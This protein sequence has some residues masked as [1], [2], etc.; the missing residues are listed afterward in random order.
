MAGML[1]LNCP[2]FD[3]SPLSPVHRN[4]KGFACP[5]TNVIG[6]SANEVLDAEMAPQPDQRRAF[7][8]PLQTVPYSNTYETQAL[9]RDEDGWAP[10]P[11]SASI[12]GPSWEAL[13]EDCQH[14]QKDFQGK[15]G[16]RRRNRAEQRYYDDLVNHV[17]ELHEADLLTK[18]TGDFAAAAQTGPAG[19]GFIYLS[20]ACNLVIFGVKAFAAV[21]SG[22][23]VLLAS[24]LDSFLDLASGSALSCMAALMRKQEKYKFPVGKTRMEPVGVVVFATLM[25]SC[26]LQVLMESAKRLLSPEQVELTT[27]VWLP[28]V[29]VVFV[30][31]ALFWYGRRVQNVLESRGQ[32]SSALEAQTDDHKNDVLT[33][34]LSLVGAFIASTTFAQLVGFSGGEL[35]VFDPLAAI[36]F[37]LYVIKNWGATALEQMTSLV[38][39]AGPAD[40]HR[41]ITYLAATHCQEIIAVDTV[42]AFTFGPRYIAEVD[43][44]LPPSMTMRVA[45]DIGESLQIR[46]ESLSEIERCYVHL[47]WETDHKPEHKS[48]V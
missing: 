29:L 6:A 27:G 38:G 31:G 14:I 2:C 20:M 37:S 4:T 11:D 41:K 12:R 33:N 26:S 46:I 30:K 24:A 48:T 42:R 8:L 32:T 34:A 16:L 19:I 47:D 36:A 17:E 23:L 10:L 25:G 43:I 40:L 44:V 15:D 1:R 3:L 5:E 21:K 22:S 18:A 7:S 9:R 28:V 13:K 39:K 45:H 35:M